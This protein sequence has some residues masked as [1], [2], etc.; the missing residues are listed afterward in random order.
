M[1]GGR[2]SVMRG[3]SPGPRA[4]VK[5]ASG[6]RLHQPEQQILDRDLDREHDDLRQRRGQQHRA[7]ASG[8]RSAPRASSASLRSSVIVIGH[9]ADLGRGQ[10][11]RVADVLAQDPALAHQ[12]PWCATIAPYS[13]SAR[14]FAAA[15]VRCQG[16]AAPGTAPAATTPNAIIGMR[17]SATCTP[18]Y[19][20]S[21]LQRDASTDGE[22]EHHRAERDRK[23]LE[24]PEAAGAV[25]VRRHEL[26]V[27]SGQARASRK[28]MKSRQS[29]RQH[30][31]GEDRAQHPARTR[32]QRSR[33]PLALARP[34]ELVVRTPR[35][36]T[37]AMSASTIPPRITQGSVRLR[38]RV[39][40]RSVSRNFSSSESGTR[41]ARRN[42]GISRVVT[43]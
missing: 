10:D 33:R 39:M 12:P 16:R 36:A 18:W 1:S 41:P 27:E 23:R 11:R 26:Q 14:R 30:Q 20:T 5:S 35:S 7:A 19:A 8:V 17:S 37:P 31:R 42:C 25:R 34:A 4:R 3:L 15:S 40:P 24:K 6:Q 13:S 2:V 29:Q 9:R 38:S 21:W 22:R 28:A 32:T 43:P